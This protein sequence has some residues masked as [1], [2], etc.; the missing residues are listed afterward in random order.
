MQTFVDCVYCYLKQAATCMSIAGVDT[1]RQHQILFELMDDIKAMDRKKTPAENSTEMLVKLYKLIGSD[2]PYR[3]AKASSNHQAL[4]LYPGLKKYLA[5]SGDKLHEALKISVAGNVIDLGINKSFDID[6]SLKQCLDTGFSRDH[7]TSFREKLNH[8]NEVL[9]VGDNAGE[10]VF[11]RIL[12]EELSAMGK[13]VIY[14]VKGGNILN[15]ATL[16]DAVLTGMDRVAQI[17]TT[18]SNYLG[19]LLHRVSA[20]AR[21]LLENSALVISKGQANFETLEHQ[22]IARGRIFFLLKIKCDSVGTVAG[23]KLGDIVFFT[24]KKP[25]L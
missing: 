20:E 3:E 25:V 24:R 10:I 2:D 18:G 12:A 15:D 4:K 5:G 16:E 1:D 9:I 21:G 11:D 22:E 19:A 13:K 14:M 7:Y 23:S 6:A 8:V 17:K